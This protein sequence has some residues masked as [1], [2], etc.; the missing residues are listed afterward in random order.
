MKVCQRISQ[1]SEIFYNI[2]SFSIISVH[3]CE[4]TSNVSFP[5]TG[6]EY[7]PTMAA[8][9]SPDA[10]TGGKNHQEDNYDE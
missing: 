5:A 8:L 3:F 7:V 2:S 6:S 10:Q 1:K 9:G 4:H